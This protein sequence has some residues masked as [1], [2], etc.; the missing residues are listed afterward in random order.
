M[1]KVTLVAALVMAAVVVQASTVKWSMSDDIMASD[2][3]YGTAYLINADGVSL[4]SLVVQ[5]DDNGDFVGIKGLADSKILGQSDIEDGGLVSG[6]TIVDDSGSFAVVFVDTTDMKFAI[7]GPQDLNV[8]S[9][10]SRDV[11][12]VD[13]ATGNDFVLSQSVEVVPEPTSV[14]LLCL[15]LAALGLKRKVA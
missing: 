15:G 6:S 8:V 13:F 5:Y 10:D 11:K 9:G 2:Y 1:K 7:A 4:G 12:T 14:A 3:S